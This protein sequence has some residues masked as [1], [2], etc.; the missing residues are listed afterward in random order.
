[1]KKLINFKSAG[2]RTQKGVTLVELLLY[3]GIF[4]ILLT[5]LT[6]IFVS[7]LDVQSESQA[8]SSVEQDGNYILAKLSYDIHRAQSITIPAANG[9]TGNSFRIVIGG[10][11]YTYSVDGNNNLILTENSGSYNLNNYNSGISN[12]SVTRLG[13]T[14]GVENAL[15]ISFIVTSRVKRGSGFETRDFQTNLSLRRQ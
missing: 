3:M 1:M 12:F 6:S 2:W 15:K 5:T 11:N 13:N 8:T 7:A 10:V 4:T 14:G 9:A